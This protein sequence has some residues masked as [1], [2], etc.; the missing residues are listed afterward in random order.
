MRGGQSRR[1]I[2]EN[3]SGTTT[4]HPAFGHLLPVEGEGEGG[5]HRD[6]GFAESFYGD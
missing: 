2:C 5:G 1:V 6:E 3:A 4:R